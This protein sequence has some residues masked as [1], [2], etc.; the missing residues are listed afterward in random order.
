MEI[1]WHERE[2]LSGRD[3]LREWRFVGGS[4]LMPELNII[5]LPCWQGGKGNGA[6]R[7]VDK[8]REVKE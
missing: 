5:C 7:R 2:G 3:H 4:S 6:R 8:G 1:V